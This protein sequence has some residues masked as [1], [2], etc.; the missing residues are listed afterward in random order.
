LN[1]MEQ[2]GGTTGV[3]NLYMASDAYAFENFRDIDIPKRLKVV[4]EE[5]L[6]LTVC[7][8]SKHLKPF[9]SG[10]GQHE[11]EL[12]VVNTSQLSFEL[13]RTLKDSYYL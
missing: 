10:H 11:A 6:T 8:H 7:E 2:P 3:E 9:L 12:I 4:I 5:G 1:L 13:L